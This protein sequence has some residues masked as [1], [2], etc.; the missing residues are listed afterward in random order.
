MRSGLLRAA[1]ALLG[2][3]ASLGAARA[4]DLPSLGGERLTG[5]DVDVRPLLALGGGVPALALRADLL[6]ALKAEF[7]DRLGGRG[8]VLLVR[9]TGLSL[10]PYALSLIHI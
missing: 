3:V 4:E 10:T 7:A 9:I 6:A 2:L 5:I 8:P 1:A